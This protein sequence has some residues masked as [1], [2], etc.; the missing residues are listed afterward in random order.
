VT[1]SDVWRDTGATI[2]VKAAAGNK[3]A[4]CACEWQESGGFSSDAGFEYG[5]HRTKGRV[6]SLE[7]RL[8]I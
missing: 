2:R 4:K 7:G 6:F 3:G 5:R 8:L 1:K